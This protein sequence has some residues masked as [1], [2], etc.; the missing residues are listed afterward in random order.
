MTVSSQEFDTVRRHY[1]EIS[2]AQNDNMKKG[3]V[4]L[5]AHSIDENPD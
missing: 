5:K 2:L 3:R 4:Q 1:V